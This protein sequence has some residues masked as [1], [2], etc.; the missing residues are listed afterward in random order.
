MTSLV[1][2]REPFRDDL[3][4]RL[5]GAITVSKGLPLP[6]P[7]GLFSSTSLRFDSPLSRLPVPPAPHKRILEENDECPYDFLL[8][9][10]C[11]RGAVVFVLEL[12][13]DSSPPPASRV[14]STEYSYEGTTASSDADEAVDEVLV[15]LWLLLAVVFLAFSSLETAS[16]AMTDENISLSSPPRDLIYIIIYL[17]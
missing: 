11:G 2:L 4:P 3:R 8:D 9:V 15:F 12:A 16:P 14:H 7:T 17:V 13:F 6:L 10:R 1:F 5:V